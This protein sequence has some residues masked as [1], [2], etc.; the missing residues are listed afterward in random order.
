VPVRTIL[1]TIG[2][3]LAMAALLLGDARA[4]RG[5]VG[6]FLDRTNALAWWWTLF[7]V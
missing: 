5:P 2:L 7:T 6:H 4:G 3:V 1:A